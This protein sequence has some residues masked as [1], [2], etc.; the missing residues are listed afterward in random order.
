MDWS[1]QLEPG[2]TLQWV[3]RPAPRCYVFRHWRRSVLG[4]LLLLLS[5]WW[6]VESSQQGHFYGWSWAAWLPLLFLLIGLYAT[7]GHLILSRL[8]WE[9]L[10]YALTD[11]RILIAQGL[12]RRRFASMPLAELTSFQLCPLGERLGTLQLCGGKS[13]HIQHLYCLEHPRLLTDRLETVLV[14]NGQAVP[15][16]SVPF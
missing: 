5:T 10:F 9:H 11:R 1:A 6:Q 7:L 12:L 2:E 16:A 13:G 14:A 4:L 3:G 8:Q 15:M